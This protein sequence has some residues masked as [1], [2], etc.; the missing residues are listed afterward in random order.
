MSIEPSAAETLEAIVAT[1]AIPFGSQLGTMKGSGKLFNILRMSGRSTGI[2]NT[3]AK[4][5]CLQLF[6]SQEVNWGEDKAAR[7]IGIH[8]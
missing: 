4:F 2:S 7:V 1:W 3:F 5:G 8:P 6:V